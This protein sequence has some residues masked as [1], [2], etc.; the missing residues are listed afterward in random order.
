MQKSENSDPDEPAFQLMMQ[1][2][3]KLFYPKITKNHAYSTPAD[4]PLLHAHETENGYYR[5]VQTHIP[6]CDDPTH[7]LF[8]LN[9]PSFEPSFELLLPS[10]ALL[11][12]PICARLTQGLTPSGLHA[13]TRAVEQAEF[14]Q[15]YEERLGA[16]VRVLAGW[17]SCSIEQH[18]KTSQ[19]FP[20]FDTAR[21]HTLQ[22]L[23]L[24]PARLPRAGI[25]DFLRANIDRLAQFELRGPEFSI[26]APETLLDAGDELDPTN[27]LFHDLNSPLRAAIRVGDF[28]VPAP[29]R[30]AP[31]SAQ[32]KL[33][34]Q[35]LDS[36]FRQLQRPA[37][38]PAKAHEKYAQGVADEGGEC[39]LCATK[40][41]SYDAHIQLASHAARYADALAAPLNRF[42]LFDA[43]TCLEYVTAQARHLRKRAIL[44]QQLHV[45]A[46]QFS[47]KNCVR[48]AFAARIFTKILFDFGVNFVVSEV[49]S[50]QNTAGEH[51]A[52][53]A[54]AVDDF[55]REQ[56]LAREAAVCEATP[57]EIEA[58]SGVLAAIRPGCFALDLL[59]VVDSRLAT[60]TAEFYAACL[61]P[62]F[63]VQRHAN[64]VNFVEK[65]LGRA[66]EPAYAVLDVQELVVDL[67]QFDVDAVGPVL[68]QFVQGVKACLLATGHAALLDSEQGFLGAVRYVRAEGS[69]ADP[70]VLRGREAI[71]AIPRLQAVYDVRAAQERLD[72]G[73]GLDR[74]LASGD[75]EPALRT[76]DDAVDYRR[77]PGA[78]RANSV[79]CFP[80]QMDP[81]HL[82][83]HKLYHEAVPGSQYTEIGEA[84]TLL[85][86]VTEDALLSLQPQFGLKLADAVLVAL[87]AIKELRKLQRGFLRGEVGI[88]GQSRTLNRMTSGH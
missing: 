68:A 45:L 38:R 75:C 70:F 34:L 57:E 44:G 69:T 42:Q 3:G 23:Q 2:F 8:Y 20:N 64:F 32:L 13:Q 6:L 59:E 85:E 1:D 29:A 71:S 63:V 58:I 50:A 39:K 15:V 41:R 84:T 40:Y 54:A 86:S 36:D 82:T 21:P 16:V 74:L 24:D 61:Y 9:I 62:E 81:D 22:E 28:H 67:K 12:R 88:I 65:M 77:R 51:A 4:S 33:L 27:T 43:R 46:L 53:D 19:N 52:A 25:A 66:L 26:F 78:A 60:L 73:V 18:T 17:I 30:I 10:P 48:Y 47:V 55:V 87:C 49:E 31:L 72:V 76:Q 35:L 80:V 79:G 5:P 7:P 14:Y 11:I 56:R 83:L 37:L